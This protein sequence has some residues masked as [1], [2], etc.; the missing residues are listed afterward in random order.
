LRVK[1]G[2]MKKLGQIW[3]ETAIYTLIAF[4]L[5]GAVLAFAKPKIDEIKDRAVIEQSIEMLKEIDD[6][7]LTLGASGNQR[8]IGLKIREGSMKIDGIQDL[9]I[10]E[11]ETPYKYAEENVEITNDNLKI[12]KIKEEGL[13]KLRITA[14]YSSSFNLTFNDQET[15]KTITKSPTQYNLVIYKGG[16][17]NVNSSRS[18]INFEIK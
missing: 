11:L 14:N 6:K 13:D 2:K 1:R 18:I 17:E 10:F 15:L 5:I 4:I 9:I 12:I 7:I 16:L 8:I 3:I